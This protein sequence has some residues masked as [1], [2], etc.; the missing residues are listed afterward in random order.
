M[1]FV[2][3]VLQ[4]AYSFANSELKEFFN[5][6]IG[7]TFTHKGVLCLQMNDRMITAIKKIANYRVNGAAYVDALVM[8][9]AA[10]FDV[11]FQENLK[12]NLSVTDLRVR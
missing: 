7:D 1:N 12:G 8:N 3:K 9:L 6:K 2:L 5:R 4:Y 11:N 10:H